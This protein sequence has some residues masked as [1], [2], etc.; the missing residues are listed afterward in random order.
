[1]CRKALL[2]RHTALE[3]TKS[4]VSPIHWQNGAIARLKPGE[5]IDKL[6]H[7]GYSTISL[8]Y[9]GIYEMTKAMKGLSHTAEIGHEFALRVMKYLKDKTDEWK[10]E[11]HI[12]FGLYG[13]PKHKWALSQ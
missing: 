13:S 12:G 9:I 1:M 11:T 10:E 2:C 7:N 8:G 5:T 4:D 3:G 6:L